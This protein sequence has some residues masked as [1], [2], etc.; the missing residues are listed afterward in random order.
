MGSGLF[1]NDCAMVGAA[2]DAEQ[3]V[4]T[5]LLMVEPCRRN[6]AMRVKL[7]YSGRNQVCR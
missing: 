6:E 5:P 2:F 4:T 3:A 1:M 7:G